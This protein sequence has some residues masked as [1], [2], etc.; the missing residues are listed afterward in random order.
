M[1]FKKVRATDL[2]DPSVFFV[3]FYVV[4]LVLGTIVTGI[5]DG[6]GVVNYNISSKTYIIIYLYL[7][8]F[9]FFS[10]LVVPS[11]FSSS[12]NKLIGFDGYCPHRTFGLALIFVS[13]GCFLLLAY[14]ALVGAVPALMADVEN[15]RAELKVGF[16]KYILLAKGFTYIGVMYMVASSK[17]HRGK[18]FVTGLFVLFGVVLLAG[19]GFRGPAAFLLLTAILFSYFCSDQYVVKRALKNKHIAFGVVFF[20][21]LVVVGYARKAQEADVRSL[22][23]MFHTFSV[24][25]SNLNLVVENFP[26]SIDFLY[27]GSFLSDLSMVVPGLNVPHISLV[28]KKM[29]GL[30]FDGEGITV[31]SPG[32]GYLNFGYFG[33]VAHAAIV[34]MLTSLPFYALKNKSD[35][36]S[37]VLLMV[38]V[39]GFSR[40]P[41]GGLGASFLFTFMPMLVV[42]VFFRMVNIFLRRI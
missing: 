16:G 35:V 42:Y 9:V 1:L 7:M 6:A 11:F 15:A 22:L 10:N 18:S 25:V 32:E 27:G 34:A 17:G 21:F 24:N 29:L 8:V 26:Q 23:A 13:V 36:H 41:Q 14:F 2:Y 20:L 39:I 4:F 28:L 19:T 33:V 37:K 31:T 40:T 38:F 30:E 3:V 5:F 12:R